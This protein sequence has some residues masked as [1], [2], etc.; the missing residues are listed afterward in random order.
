MLRSGFCCHSRKFKLIKSLAAF[1]FRTHKFVLITG[2]SSTIVRVSFLFLFFPGLHILSALSFHHILIS[3]HACSSQCYSLPSA[4]IFGQH[5]PETEKPSKRANLPPK[6]TTA[7]EPTHTTLAFKP[8]K[9]T[10]PALT[11]S[12]RVSEALPV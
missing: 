12:L 5:S 11:L 3:V 4:G 7:N 10:L 6:T 1:T 9:K 8:A 2:I